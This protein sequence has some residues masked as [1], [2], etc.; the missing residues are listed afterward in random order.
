MLPKPVQSLLIIVTGIALLGYFAY[1][2]SDWVRLKFDAT[3]RRGAQAELVGKQATT[4]YK[5]SSGSTGVVMT[6]EYQVNGQSY[7]DD[8]GIQ[9][10]RGGTDSVRIGQQIPILYNAS[11]PG[12]A[13]FAADLSPGEEDWAALVL[14]LCMIGLGVAQWREG[15]A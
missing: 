13:I 14:G 10:F 8:L 15:E 11:D 4:G 5:G 3:Q 1:E 12:S 9:N 2:R 6:V 7:R